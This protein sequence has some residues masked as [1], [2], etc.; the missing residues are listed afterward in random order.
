MPALTV[1]EEGPWS[2]EHPY[3]SAPIFSGSVSGQL[4]APPWAAGCFFTLLERL[5]ELCFTA[6]SL[7]GTGSSACL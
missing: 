5:R 7:G 1:Q 2:Y 6:P 3:N 4:S